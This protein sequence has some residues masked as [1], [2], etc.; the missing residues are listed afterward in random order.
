MNEELLEYKIEELK[1]AFRAKD[2][3]TIEIFEKIEEK[4]EE[5]KIAQGEHTRG[6][7]INKGYIK[8]MIKEQIQEA[9]FKVASKWGAFFT[10]IEKIV[11]RLAAV[12]FII[13]FVISKINGG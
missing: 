8:S 1:E 9:P 11:V 5:I 2:I 13:Y 10:N 6:C 3:S 7:P 4:I 12:G